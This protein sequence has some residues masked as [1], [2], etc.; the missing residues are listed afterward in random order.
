MRQ[1]PF[2]EIQTLEEMQ[3]F[4]THLI[5]V[6]HLNFSNPEEPMLDYIIPGTKDWPFY[7]REEADERQNLLDDCFWLCEHLKI[8]P[9]DIALSI[10]NEILAV[11]LH[12][13]TAELSTPP[14]KNPANTEEELTTAIPCRGAGNYWI[15]KAW[16]ILENKEYPAIFTIGRT[17][18]YLHLNG[19]WLQGQTSDYTY[20][21]S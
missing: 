7:N 18:V 15:N 16:F 10:S 13:L 17:S 20:P 1:V 14:K 11:Q 6:E 9:C 12:N 5:V 2:K 21:Q 3:A 4:F 8:D 19:W